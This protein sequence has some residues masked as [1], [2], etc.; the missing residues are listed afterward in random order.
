MNLEEKINLAHLQKSSNEKYITNIENDLS[1]S[2]ETIFKLQNEIKK[3]EIKFDEE[4]F[5]KQWSKDNF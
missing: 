1:K 4:V 5:S 3:I 2:K